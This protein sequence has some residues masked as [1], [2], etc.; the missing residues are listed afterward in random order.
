MDTN[1]NIKDINQDFFNCWELIK[2]SIEEKKER[3]KNSSKNTQ[4]NQKS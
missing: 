4:K 3:Q 2:K 1:S